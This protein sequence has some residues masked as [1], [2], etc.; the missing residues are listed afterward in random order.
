M[1]QIND[2]QILA[3]ANSKAKGFYKKSTRFAEKIALIHSELSEALEGD[4]KPRMSGYA[5]D[6]ITPTLEIKD[7]QEFINEFEKKFKDTV[8]DE[9]SDVVIRVLDLAEYHEIALE[10]HILAKMRYNALREYKH[11]KEY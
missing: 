7:N 4:R 9:L 1:G 2:L 3:H 6:I 11:G 8:D 5:M 10:L